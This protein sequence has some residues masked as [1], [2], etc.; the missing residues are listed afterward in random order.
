MLE[1]SG[2]EDTYASNLRLCLSCP[3]HPLPRELVTFSQS[4]PESIGRRDYIS[5]FASF[6]FTY[7]SLPVRSRGPR[8]LVSCFVCAASENYVALLTV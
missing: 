1:A 2:T 5:L 7:G 3:D 8:V 6:Q 4:T